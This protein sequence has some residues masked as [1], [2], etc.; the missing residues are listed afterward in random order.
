MKLFILLAVSSSASG[1]EDSTVRYLANEGVMVAHGN[2]KILF[3]PL[4][5]NSYELYQRVPQPMRDAI[6]AGASPYDG[7]DA[8]FISHFHGDHFSARDMLRLLRERQGIRLYA[9]A[10]AVAGMRQIATPDDEAVFER[11]TIF[12][13]EYGDAPVFVR[14][15]DLLIEAVHVPHSG[16]PTAR[17]D[18]Q[19]IAFRVTLED[20]STVLHL[21]DADARLVHFEQDEIYWDERQ[22]D[23]AFPPYWFLLS[24]DG[25][26]ILDD[27]VRAN[28]SIGIHVPAEFRED[29]STI[30]EEL[31]GE[32]LFLQPGEGR[33]FT[34]TQ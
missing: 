21:G 14:T 28:H 16:W 11:V 13:F 20:T 7:V 4:F 1:Q 3:D 8:V 6:F 23:L 31:I 22:V 15:D 26:E 30:P 24:D 32:D 2:T 12:D 10:Q 25:R 27:R 34:G 17:T 9:P 33:R 5:E 29:A 18:V 19:N